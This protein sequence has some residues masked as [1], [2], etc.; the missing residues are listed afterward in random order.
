MCPAA[1]KRLCT[2]G[3]D[4]MYSNCTWQCHPL[5][6]NDDGAD[7]DKTAQDI[8]NHSADLK[9]CTGQYCT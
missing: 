2:R 7:P 4:I 5:N 3:L 8:A 9:N 6:A 1:A